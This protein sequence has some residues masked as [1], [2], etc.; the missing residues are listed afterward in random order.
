[1]K[2]KCLICG[3]ESFEEGSSC[4]LATNYRCSR[5][6]ALHN[7]T[8]FGFELLHLSAQPKVK[9]TKTGEVIEFPSVKSALEFARSKPDY[10][11][12]GHNYLVWDEDGVLV[13]DG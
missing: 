12:L 5:C 6:G 3:C 4:G 10:C 7:E 9:I 2:Q 8:P 13:D 1:M 11:P